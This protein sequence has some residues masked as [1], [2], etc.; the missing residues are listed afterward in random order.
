MEQRINIITLGTSDLKKSRD[1]Y[2][3]GLGWKASPISDNYDGIV[4]FKLGTLVFSLF[5]REALAEDA[6][7]ASSVGG[8]FGGITLAHNAH[9][10]D[11]VNRIMEC[12]AKAGATITKPA[13]N[14]SWGGYSGYFADP[15]GHLWEIA[16]NP[17]LPL[18]ENGALQIP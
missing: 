3:N 18:D 15:D 4:F 2:E 17:Y 8:G 12:A 13:Q 14:T 16:W 6:K 9:D 1:F 10:K 5:P 11:A 7:A